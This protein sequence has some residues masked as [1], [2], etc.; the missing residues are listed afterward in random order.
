MNNQ[1]ENG[2]N[3]NSNQ[4]TMLMMMNA[5]SRS[6]NKMLEYTLMMNMMNK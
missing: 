2:F 6:D 1:G 4:M 5:N 3:M